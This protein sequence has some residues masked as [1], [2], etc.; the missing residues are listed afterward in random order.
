MSN[1]NYHTIIVRSNVFGVKSMVFVHAP[2][3]CCKGAVGG[4]S[5]YPRRLEQTEQANIIV[6]IL[7]TTNN[8]YIVL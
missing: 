4:G 8:K 7:C 5:C 1:N 3:F 6:L 2:G